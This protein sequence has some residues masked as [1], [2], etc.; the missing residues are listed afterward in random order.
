MSPSTEVGPGFQQ[1]RVWAVVYKI[2]RSLPPL[3]MVGRLLSPEL[4]MLS[5]HLYTF[6]DRGIVGKRKLVLPKNT[7]LWHSQEM[8]LEQQDEEI[9]VYMNTEHKNIAIR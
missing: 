4:N 2:Y 7:A 9:T 6:L 8:L 1:S 3:P 5:I